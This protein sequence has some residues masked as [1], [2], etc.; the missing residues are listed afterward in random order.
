[1]SFKYR[2]F[3]GLFLAMGMVVAG[4]TPPDDPMLDMMELDLSK[5]KIDDLSRTMDFISSEVRFSQKEFKEK[6]STNL[7]RW[8]TYSDEKLDR[9]DWQEDRLSKPIFEANGSLQLLERNADFS[10][11]NTDAYYLQAS[12]W[13]GRI[14]D[15]VTD[16]KSLR[17]FELYR[18]AAD[19]YQQPD[20]VEDGLSEIMKKLH[21]GMDDQVAENLAKSLKVFD[22]MMRNVQLLPDPSPTDDEIEEVRLFD[23]EGSLAGSGVPGLGYRRYPWQVML[24]GRGDYVERAKLLILGLRQLEMDAVMLAT[25]SSEGELTP[26]AVGVLIGGEYYLFDTKMALPIPGS[27]LGSIATLSDVRANPELISSLDLTTDESLEENTQYWVKPDQLADLVALVYVSPES[28]SRRMLALESSLAGD[29][30]LVLSSTSDAVASR[31]PQVA[32]LE[33]EAWDIAFETHQYRQA[34]REALGKTSNNVL[35]PKL[36]WYYLEESY[37]DHFVPYRTA[38]TRFFL[39]KFQSTRDA[40]KLNAIQSYQRLKYSDIVI[41]QLGSDLV[42]QERHGIRKDKQTKQQ[43]DQEVSSVQSQMRLIRRDAGLFLAQCMFDNG[44]PGAAASWLEILQDEPNAERWNDGVIYLLGRS[45]EALMDYDRAIEVLDNPT[46]T[47]SHGNLIRVR[48]WKEL[49]LRF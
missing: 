33:I 26:W 14:V 6:V 25:R 13:I 41:D 47:Q 20:D 2:I 21:P 39:G 28:V 3:T 27:T 31:L 7:N 49:V 15:R 19:D 45:F 30:R 32:Q 29:L 23:R 38:R 35:A 40:V 9:A 8:V 16:A 17:P 22:W 34:V 36:A 42:L 24:Y 48:I 44:N 4:C 11:L 5:T 46:T 18:V 1:M 12:E 43:F 37:I 10:F